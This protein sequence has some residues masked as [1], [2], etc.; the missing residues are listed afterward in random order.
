MG[1]HKK[2]KTAMLTEENATAVQPKTRLWQKQ[3]MT[4][5]MM[6]I[7]SRIITYTAG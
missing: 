2:L 4:S 1:P 5:E 7:P 6:P 3:A